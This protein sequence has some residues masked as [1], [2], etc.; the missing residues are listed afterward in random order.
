MAAELGSGWEATC[1]GAVRGA[2]DALRPD[3]PLNLSSLE[4]TAD[5]AHSLDVD[6]AGGGTV[7]VAIQAITVNLNYT[8]DQRETTTGNLHLSAQFVRKEPVPALPA[9]EAPKSG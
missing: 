8:R 4:C 9:P 2:L 6:Q 1:K 7:G 3:D 5:Y